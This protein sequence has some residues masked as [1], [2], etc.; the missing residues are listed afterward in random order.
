MEALLITA[1]TTSRM[2]GFAISKL[3]TT[4]TYTCSMARDTIIEADEVL[5]PRGPSTRGARQILRKDEN[6]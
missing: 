5:V 3:T 2:R 4:K 6:M 1:T